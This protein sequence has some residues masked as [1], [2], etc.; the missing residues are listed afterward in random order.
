VRG[1]RWRVTNV[2]YGDGPNRVMSL[3]GTGAANAGE[4]R[5]VITPFDLVEPVN[6]LPRLRLVSMPRWRLA[7][8]AI[9][10]DR[11]CHCSAG[12]LRAAAAARIDLHSY[13]LEPALAVVS[14]RASR[15]LIADEVGLGKTIQTGVIVSELL[16]RAAAERVLVLAPAGVRS[17]WQ[18]ELR[19]RFSIESAVMN[20][21]EGRRRSAML[22]AGVNPWTTLPVV[23]TSIDYVKRP[24][25]LA[26]VRSV[27]WD[28]VVVDEAH[29][30][31]AG[32]DR[33]AAAAAVCRDAAYVV[34]LTATPHHGDPLAF[35]SLCDLGTLNQDALLTFRR[36]RREIRAGAERRIHRM[37][38]RP[39]RDEQRMY[40]SLGRLARAVCAEPENNGNNT[41]SR[42]A[43]SVLYKRAFSSAYSLAESASRRLATLALEAEGT[44]IAKV[45]QLFL[46]LADGSDYETADAAP[47]SRT[48]LL[49]NREQEHRMLADVLEASKAAIPVQT[50]LAALERLLRRLGSRG[51]RAIVF[52]EY[53]DTLAHVRQ[54]LAPQALLI[55]GGMTVEER[56]RSVDA[57]TVGTATLLLATDAAGEGLNLH[58][59]CRVVVNLELPWNPMRLE[60]RIGR[61]DRIGQTRRVH[62]FHLVARHEG[63][64]AILDR[65]ESRVRAAGS[66]VGAGDPLGFMPEEADPPAVHGVRLLHEAAAAHQ[67]LLE[68]RRL[69]ADPGR[70]EGRDTPEAADVIAATARRSRLRAALAGRSLAIFRSELAGRDH[71]RVATRLAPISFVS[72]GPWGR[73]SRRRILDELA[74]P[75]ATIDPQLEQWRTANA[76]VH[77]DFWACRLAREQAIAVAA[78]EKVDAVQPG[79]FDRRGDR[80]FEAEAERRNAREV[81]AR[82]RMA[83]A[84]RSFDTELDVPRLALVLFV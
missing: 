2:A 62:A 21:R 40:E 81:Q 44:D 73:A 6:R 76:R 55:H 48:P 34:L 29:Q 37:Q 69:L 5:V 83:A 13:Q 61:V 27:R 59:A 65:L 12:A 68:A 54:T 60:Q 78:N 84:R 20:T 30:M 1:A 33:H 70:N 46:P 47:D 22:P 74:L 17:Q 39:S 11:A 72:R 63:E 50:K 66:A 4:I 51:E 32:S 36:T 28:I 56:Q 80:R 35:R 7:C 15:V 38:I 25:V 14:G 82:E 23:V 18:F 3:V 9:F 8:R 24:E 19:E 41:S 43:L 31:T 57:F 71:K 53:R 67:Q 16:V 64:L 10:A 49:G 52:T 77:R 58:A 45:D 26:A 79:L 42:L 75:A